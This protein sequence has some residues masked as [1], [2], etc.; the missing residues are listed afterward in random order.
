[1][2]ILKR[3]ERIEF[4]FDQH[5]SG[6]FKNMQSF[7]NKF[8]NRKLL[9]ARRCSWRRQRRLLNFILEPLSNTFSEKKKKTRFRKKIA[10]CQQ[11]CIRRATLLT[12]APTTSKQFQKVPTEFHSSRDTGKA[13][14]NGTF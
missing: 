8:Y 13:G 11:K 7:R 5:F 2:Q 3:I 1:M 12:T 6:H 10:D 14:A 4:R 9:L